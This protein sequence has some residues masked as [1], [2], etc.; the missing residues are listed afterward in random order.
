MDGHCWC[1]VNSSNDIE[2]FY[3]DDDV[4][5]DDDD[6][7]PANLLGGFPAAVAKADGRTTSCCGK[8]HRRVFEAT[9]ATEM[10]SHRHKSDTVFI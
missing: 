10:L 7:S 8:I 2:R 6:A 9:K 3:D 1:R 4:D 5:D